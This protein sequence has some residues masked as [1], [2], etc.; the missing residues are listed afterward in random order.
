MKDRP[1][2][3]R[4]H[5]RKLLLIEYNIQKFELHLNWKYI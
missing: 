1:G 2:A 3:Y 5:L 4:M